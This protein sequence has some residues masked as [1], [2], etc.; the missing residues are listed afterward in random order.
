VPGREP[1]WWY[2]AGSQWQATL[3]APVGLVVGKIATARLSRKNSYRSRLPV[4]CIGNFTA[5]GSGK[6]PLALLVARLVS[7]EEREP[8][9]LSRGYGG[10][11][12]GPIHVD[13]AVHH[14]ADVGDEPLLLARQAPAV[15]SRD[16]ASGA[17]AIE[18]AASGDAVIIMDDGL[19]NPALVKDLTIA[20]VSGDRGLGNGRVIP[21]GP[22]RAPLSA[23]IGLADM[24]V[25][26]GQSAQ[27]NAWLHSLRALAQVPIIRAQTRASGSAA[28]FKGRRV[29]AYAGIANPE[30]FFSMLA[31]I[32]A[33][34]VERRVFD[35][36]HGFSD[37]EARDLLDTARRSSADLVTT[38]KDLARLAGATGE[39]KALRERSHAFAIETVIDGDDLAIFRAKIREA[40][41]R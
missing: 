21:A 7:Q 6:T 29:I 26:T 31:N 3:L 23:Q 10:R 17:K 5:G 2:G 36:H 32:G 38:E 41:T 34:V 11:L 9:F 19:Q 16:R 15:I 4:I 39:G 30:R 14:S 8:W 40:L 24:I 25:V 13:T 12:T 33:D 35:D 1:R 28:K 37:S 22:L 27:A 18:A 20:V